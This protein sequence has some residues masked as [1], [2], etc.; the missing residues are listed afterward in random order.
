LSGTLLLSFHITV[1]LALTITV[2]VQSS[3]LARLR[4]LPS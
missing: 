3:E 4:S 1:A 2:G